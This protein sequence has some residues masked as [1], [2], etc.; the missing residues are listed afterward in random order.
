MSITQL[1]SG[2]WRVQIRRKHLRVDRV[3]DT[4]AEAREAEQRYLSTQRNPIGVSLQDAWQD[5]VESLTYLQKKSRTRDTEA[6]RIKRALQRFGTRSVSSITSEDVESYITSR[7]KEGSANSADAIRLEVAALSALMNHCRKRGWI[8]ANPCIGIKRPSATV[9]PRRM[10]K[11]DEGALIALLS[12]S[13]FRFRSAAR[14]CLL[15]RET[16]ARPGEW[17]NATHDDVDLENARVVFQN[18]KYRG[19]PRT[20]PL[21]DAAIRLVADQLEDTLI[22][23]FD[24][25]GGSNLLFPTLGRDGTV[26]PLHYTGALRDAKKARLLP[27]TLKAH[28]GRHEFIS[29]LLESTDLDDA[30]IMALVGHHSPASMEVYKHV[31]NVRF[32]PAIEGLEPERRV[33]RSQALASSLGVPAPLIASY[34]E[35]RRNELA[36]LGEEDRGDELLYSRSTLTEILS[37]VKKLGATPSDR[38][39]ALARIAKAIHSSRARSADHSLLNHLPLHPE[40]GERR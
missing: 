4:Q 30:R 16:G 24:V 3:F 33:Q 32:L 8:A 7:M 5:Y 10:T 12:H 19:Q 26:R 27:K 31:R 34:L 23:H 2:R 11:E 15:V 38:M 6:S 20:V 14:L 36:E 1:P 40:E 28:T 39:T 35:R 13:N 21:S 9:K 25:F 29:T 22:D 37:V 17:R 18:T